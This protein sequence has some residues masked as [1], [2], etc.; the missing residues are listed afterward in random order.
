MPTPPAAVRPFAESRPP[1]I[2]TG[3]WPASWIACP[4]V[5]G[6]SFVWAARLRVEL[7]QAATMRLH[8]TADQRYALY[9]DGE[10]VGRG[11]ER[12]DLLHWFYETV[13]LK[14]TAGTHMLVARVWTLDPWS[15]KAPGA[16]LTVRP[17]LLVAAESPFTEQ[18]STGRGAWETK[19]VDGYTFDP[20]TNHCAAHFAGGTITLDGRAYPWGVERGEGDG[21]QAAT[22]GERA[23]DV[24]D[25]WGEYR[26]RRLMPG[27]LPPMLSQPW[28]RG[29]VRLV[30]DGAEGPVAVARHLHDEASAW[31]SWW[32]G[33]GTLTV[34]AGTRRR[35]IVD[36]D[37]YVCAYATVVTTAGRGATVH[38]SWAESL[39]RNDRGGSVDKGHRDEIEGKWFRGRGDTFV[40]D[41]GEGR[42][43]G[44]L[45]WSCGRYVEVRVQTGDEAL[46]IDALRLEETRY[47]LPDAPDAAA[48]SLSESRFNAAV[49]IMWR[50]LQM[51]SHE[52]YMD[53]PYYEQLMYAGDTRLEA[54]VT[55]VTCEDDRLPLKAVRL[56]GASLTAMGLTQSRYPSHQ[57]QII[58]Q[59]ALFWAAMVHD[60]ACWRGRRELVAS[61]MPTVRCI[62]ETFLHQVGEDGLVRWPEGWNWVDW[63]PGFQNGT[64]PDDG[65]GHSGINQAQLIYVLGL[66]A[67]LEQWLG[68]SALAERLRE[69]AAGLRAAMDRTFWDTSRG[70]YADTPSH[71][72]FSEHA[73]CY[74]VLSGGCDE[75]QLQRIADRLLAPDADVHRATIYFQHYLFETL[76]LAR[77]PDALMSKLDLWYSLPGLGLKTALEK[78]EPSRSDCHAWSSHPIC[79]A[80]TSVI[81]I[82][83]TGL[84]GERISVRPMLGSLTWAKG[85]VFTARGPVTADLRCEGDTLIATLTLPPGLSGQL[86]L[87]DGPRDLKAGTQTLTGP[88]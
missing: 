61:H 3:Q 68:E 6:P 60:L 27:T 12:G 48:L 66:V 20:P 26:T 84:G 49:P 34:P 51:C 13:D 82:R 85:R 45:W 8:I 17:G 70:L 81:G 15:F 56:F 77:R 16:Q 19:V 31:E 57:P 46:T 28:T 33:Q 58:P 71:D 41:G 10:L 14:L 62:V 87:S 44:P 88:L 23:R 39:F 64:P 2:H 86:Q 47:P 5:A 69:R 74:M 73:N 9:L 29:R 78:P 59:F 54:L 21:W 4:D 63:V 7:A 22:P 32:R 11:P 18:V 42:A 75:G 37:D 67:E 55:Y 50:T 76:R 38:L 52:T 80:L 35:V 72:S 36:L 79:H 25:Q 53:C 43:M 30:D 83:P 1:R 40:A 65:S 24:V